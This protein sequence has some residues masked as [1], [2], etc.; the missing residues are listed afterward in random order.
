MLKEITEDITIEQG[1]DIPH[2]VIPKSLNQL[3]QP[4]LHQQPISYKEFQVGTLQHVYGDGY[5][6]GFGNVPFVYKSKTT[7]IKTVSIDEKTVFPLFEKGGI[8]NNLPTD[9][10]FYLYSQEEIDEIDLVAS[11]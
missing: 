2:Y 10:T 4:V 11:K 6:F 3:L 8:I 5:G 7:D 1:V 9:L